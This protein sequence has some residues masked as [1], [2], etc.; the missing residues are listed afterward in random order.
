MC[1]ELLQQREKTGCNELVHKQ[2]EMHKYEEIM[3]KR[4][5][6]AL[7]LKKLLKS[8]NPGLEKVKS[9]QRLPVADKSWRNIE[10][11]LDITPKFYGEQ[12]TM[13]VSK[14]RKYKLYN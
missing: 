2:E 9:D 5:N 3:P 10:H 14:K 4:R 6:T 7:E 11:E 8:K 1:E 13:T 12:F